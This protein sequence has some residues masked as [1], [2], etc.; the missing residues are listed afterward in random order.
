MTEP[1]IRL[2]FCNFTEKKQDGLTNT[3]NIIYTG[4]P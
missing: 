1:D 3:Q 4:I 2:V